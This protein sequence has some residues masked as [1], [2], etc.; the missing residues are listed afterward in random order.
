ME[1]APMKPEYGILDVIANLAVMATLA[2]VIA[3][4]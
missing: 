3:V 4:F 2:V 1:D